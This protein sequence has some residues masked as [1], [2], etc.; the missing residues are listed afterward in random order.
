MKELL[1]PELWQSIISGLSTVGAALLGRLAWHT[2]LV[3]QAKRKFFSIHMMLELPIA[4]GTGFAA[5]GVL[6]W[7]GIEE[8]N[9]LQAGIIAISYLGPGGI[10]HLLS[11]YFRKG[12][13]Q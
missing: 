2:R 9:V 10:E 11:R 3:Q 8:G 13:P 4:V 12:K 7:Y 1:P 5:L 6:E